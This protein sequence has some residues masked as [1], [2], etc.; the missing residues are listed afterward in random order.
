MRRY[1]LTTSCHQRMVVQMMMR[2]YGQVVTLVMPINRLSLKHKT[3]KPIKPS[4]SLT[5]KHK[6]GTLIFA[7]QK[8]TQL[9]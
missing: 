6:I 3:P 4:P 1:E 5:P 2:I 9:L 8:M 7:G